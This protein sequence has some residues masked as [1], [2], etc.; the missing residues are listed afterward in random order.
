MAMR[1]NYLRW[2]L[3]ELLVFEPVDQWSWRME[4]WV[5]RKGHRPRRAAAYPVGLDT[6]AVYANN[7]QYL[8]LSDT[9]ADQIRAKGDD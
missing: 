1:R 9:A 2:T 8:T 6:E 4:R 7:P 3:D 5:L